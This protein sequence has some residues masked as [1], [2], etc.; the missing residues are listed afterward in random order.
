MMKRR[1]SWLL[2][3]CVSVQTFA[4]DFKFET[5][6][7]EVT[8]SGYYRIELSPELLGQTERALSDLRVYDQ[9]GVE[10][11]YVTQRES[12]V[13]SQSLFR[14]YE[15]TDKVYK[16]NA[17]S[18][19]IFRN[20]T[21]EA[22]DNVSFLVKNTE[23]KKRA[24][25]SGS[26]DQENWYVIKDN[27]LLHAMQ[28][29]GETSEMKM[30][31]FPLSDYAYFK[32]EINDSSRLP[33]NILKVG[34]YDTKKIEG[35]ST[36][37]TCPRIEQKDSAKTSF[38]TMNFPAP[39]Y[40]EQLQFSVSGSEY[41]SRQATLK[42]KRTG[43]NK[44]NKPYT[45]YESLG[46][47]DLNSNN[48]NEFPF[49]GISGQ[50]LILEIANLDNQPLRVNQVQV[51]YLNRYLVADLS[52]ASEYT[53]KFGDLSLRKPQYDLEQ[54]RDQIP[55]ELAR[56]EHGSIVELEQE[57]KKKAGLW[58]NKYLVWFVIAVVGF[59]LTYI[60]LKMVKEMGG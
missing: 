1:T 14:E 7:P 44:K 45:Y 31:N 11:P 22:I 58:N 30:L 39:V 26:D 51:S 41:F 43:L 13:S 49:Q 46:R 59:G 12:A 4:Q 54:F 48:K 27:Y 29:T 25:L 53:I 42:V 55:E 34:Y 20:E 2:G 40:M 10:Q 47:F 18:Y 8:E 5:A 19:L 52:A 36:S 6:V 15:I 37:Y 23:A 35:L 24:R 57:E 33:I 32:L 50:E 16:E 38:V 56:I 21:K 60:S 3:L 9:A 28:S 17:V